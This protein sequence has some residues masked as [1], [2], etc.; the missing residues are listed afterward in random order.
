M[1]YS[2]IILKVHSGP[3]W[4]RT[5]ATLIFIL[6]NTE[7]TVWVPRDHFGD[8]QGSFCWYNSITLRVLWDPFGFTLGTALAV[9]LG[10]FEDT[11]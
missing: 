10:H 6:G 1:G 3:L 2:G 8:T 11:L 7:V 9:L 5:G 4:R